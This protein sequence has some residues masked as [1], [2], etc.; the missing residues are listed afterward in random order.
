MG[1]R[2]E[3]LRM[4]KCPYCSEDIQDQ[5][6]KCKH[7]GEWLDGFGRRQSFDDPDKGSSAARAVAKG[8]KKK[9]HDDI[10][11]GCLGTIVL[12]ISIIVGMANKSFLIGFIAF[13][14]PMCI[15]ASKYH[16]E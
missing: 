5:A 12:F 4:K 13:M 15:L 11:F 3:A 16:R 10:K 6:K 1:A 8:M 7:C 14:V 2:K 9:E